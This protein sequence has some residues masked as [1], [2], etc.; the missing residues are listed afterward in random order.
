MNGDN[1]SADLRALNE[2]VRQLQETLQQRERV[3]E[4]FAKAVRWGVL[5]FVA[6][7]VMTGFIISDRIGIAYAQNDEG[8]GQ[9][10]NVVEALN[11]INA[12]LAIFGMVG[13]T[14]G[15]ASPV[16]K[17]AMQNNKDIQNQT[18]QYLEQRGIAVT[19]ENMGKYAPAA[20]VDNV[21]T[22]VVDV[23]I[24]MQ[25]VREDSNQFRDLV[26]NDPAIALKAIKQELELMNRALSSVPVMAG[27]MDVMNR[28]MAS[29]SHSMGTTMGRMG[30]WAPW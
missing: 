19:E 15:Q 6:A 2:T 20:V 24:L 9:V 11:N 21:V 18:K 1:Q 7:I 27:Q 14:L 26:E 3:Y 16:I 30:S 5:G 23:G 10:K 28:N 8:L 12:N 4:Q 29:M 22:T 17:D 25:R 13:Q